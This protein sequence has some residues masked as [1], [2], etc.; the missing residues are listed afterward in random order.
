MRPPRPP[1]RSLPKSSGP[2]GYVSVYLSDPLAR[3]PVRAVTKP[4]DNKSD[5]NLETGTYGVFST[6]QI[7]MRTSIAT[8]GVRYIFFV[9]THRPGKRVLTGYYRIGWYAPGPDHDYVLAASSWRFVEPIAVSS[10]TGSLR[11]AV[12]VRRGYEG[13]DRE[14][15]EHLRGLLDARADRTAD[16]VQE[17]RRLEALSVRYTGYSYP[18]WTRSTGWS[19][20]DVPTYLAATPPTEGG[21]QSNTA[22]GGRWICSAC[23]ARSISKA[24]LKRCGSCGAIA[25]LRPDTGNA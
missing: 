5:P 21:P 11:D 12:L 14:Q 15:A 1:W 17:I 7:K 19:W 20:S 3:Y 9:T 6:C 13:L 23:E 18:S 4:R 22:P 8:K 2:D 16:Y 24:R 10:L 25:T